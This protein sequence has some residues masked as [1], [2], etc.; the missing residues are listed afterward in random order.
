MAPD[1]LRCRDA[2]RC[3]FCLN[4][5]YHPIVSRRSQRPG[6]LDSN[7]HFGWPDR[8]ETNRGRR[9]PDCEQVSKDS[10]TEQQRGCTENHGEGITALR[11]VPGSL[12]CLAST[13]TPP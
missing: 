12:S 8:G 5:S 3:S 6:S 10:N 7:S 1:E 9:S 4:D 13:E 11:A 2:Y